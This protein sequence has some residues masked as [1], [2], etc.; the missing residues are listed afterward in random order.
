MVPQLLLVCKI[1]VTLANLVV[2]LVLPM[3][4]LVIMVLAASLLLLALTAGHME[5]VPI[6]A[7]SVTPSSLVIRAVL[8]S[9]TCKVVALATAIGFQLDILGLL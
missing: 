2:A 4:A 6:P 7:P 9:P 1:Q 5:P 8:P 3:L